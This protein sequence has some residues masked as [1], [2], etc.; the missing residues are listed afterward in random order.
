M[1]RGD[2]FGDGA[3]EGGRPVLWTCAG[4]RGLRATWAGAELGIALDLRMLPFPPRWAAREYLE[5]NP[6]GT[7]P[8]LVHDGYTMT[9]SSAIAHYL[10]T[11]WGPT[12]LAVGPDEA[13]YGAYLDF[14]HHADATIT[15]PQTVYMRFVLFEKDRGLQAA[16]EAYAEWYAK[17]LIKAERR[18]E[19]REFLCGERF[20]MADIAVAY[21]LWLS[22]RVGLD[23]LVPDSLKDW[24]TRMVA[25]PGFAAAMAAEKSASEVAGLAATSF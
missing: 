23:H 20:T 8:A 7:I 14:L 22:S 2:Q 21:G 4:S 25:R 15:F 10:A 18:L 17:R 3:I 12:P 6:L 5:V 19:G 9:E 11:R 16:G 1:G 24:R 13:D